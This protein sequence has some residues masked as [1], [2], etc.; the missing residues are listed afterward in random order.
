[1]TPEERKTRTELGAKDRCIMKENVRTRILRNEDLTVIKGEGHKMTR[2]GD[3][4]RDAHAHAF[5]SP[6]TPL[7]TEEVYY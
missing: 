4:H 2:H 3:A 7:S 6:Q 5:R 1:L